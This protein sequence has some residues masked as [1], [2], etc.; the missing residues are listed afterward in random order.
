MDEA[1]ADN[2]CSAL[3]EG[4]G[5]KILE[6]RSV[7]SGGRL[8]VGTPAWEESPVCAGLSVCVLLCAWVIRRHTAQATRWGRQR[9]RRSK[10]SLLDILPRCSRK[11]T[12]RRAPA[13]SPSEFQLLIIFVC[14]FA[15]CGFACVFHSVMFPECAAGLLCLCYIRTR[16]LRERSSLTSLSELILWEGECSE[17]ELNVKL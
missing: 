3:K 4:T 11:R 12:H 17:H 1:H 7:W 10:A 9:R 6:N 15:H 5:R 16:R 14:F 8:G 2:C 13:S